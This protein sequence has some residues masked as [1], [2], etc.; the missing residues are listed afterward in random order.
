MSSYVSVTNKYFLPFAISDAFSTTYE[1]TY[2]SL[3]NADQSSYD[4]D[5]PQTIMDGEEKE[6]TLSDI[7]KLF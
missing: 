1:D 6:I 3:L 5:T 7:L 4:M 2:P